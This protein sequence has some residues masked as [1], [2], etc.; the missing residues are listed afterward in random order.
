MPYIDPPL[1]VRFIA[2]LLL[3]AFNLWSWTH[4]RDVIDV[5]SGVKRRLAAVGFLLMFLPSSIVL[6]PTHSSVV[7]IDA[8]ALVW[9]LLA[10]NVFLLVLLFTF[11]KKKLV[12]VGASESAK[13]EADID[14]R[15]RGLLRASAV[16]IPIL[17]LN[18]SIGDLSHTDDYE[19]V[20]KTVSI[21]RLA[22]KLKGLRI[23]MI[24]DIH[25]G[26]FMSKTDI[27]P[28]IGRIN[29]LQP[30]LIL[31]P[32][33]FVQSRNEEVDPLCESIRGLRAPYGIY[34]CTGNHEYI[35]DVEYI[36]R[37]IQNA[38]VTM[39]RNEHRVLDIH[40]EKL[41]LIG[42]DDIRAGH[43]FHSS[44]RHAVRGLDPSL[45]NITMCHKPYYFEEASEYDL[46]LVVSGH[47]HGGQIV[48]ARVFNI[49][50]TPAALLSGYVE[51]LYRLDRAQMYVT[52]GIGM[53]GLPIRLNCP[54]EITVL[55]L[56]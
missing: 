39:L 27:D 41:A 2:F 18:K 3:S 7:W 34:G 56:E 46:D 17:T 31:L 19:V 5:A 16:G 33:D 26:P 12:H 11:R 23:A 29:S 28:Y 48:L 47:T 32:G 40:G 4:L 38:G 6:L 9:L 15:R 20:Y 55:T 37:E 22:D 36:S 51:G 35:A 21:R 42:L 43:P 53:S 52:R 25:S 1:F 30:D 13:T 24:A 45:P 54:P 44:F 8:Q 10:W 50:I 14:L 49:V